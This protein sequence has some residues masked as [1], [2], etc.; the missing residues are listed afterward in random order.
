MLRGIA[1]VVFA[2]I[3]LARPT[4]TL[5]PLTEPFSLCPSRQHPHGTGIPGASHQGSAIA[6]FLSNIACIAAGTFTRL[7]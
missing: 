2:I 1:V 4:S 5:G 7:A 6:Q 3:V